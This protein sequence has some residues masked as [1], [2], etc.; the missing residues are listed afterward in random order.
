LPCPALQGKAGHDQG[1]NFRPA[2]SCRAGQ[3]VRASGQPCPVTV[4]ALD[5]HSA[6]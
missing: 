2:L 5:D 4:S 3:G 1:K 6:I